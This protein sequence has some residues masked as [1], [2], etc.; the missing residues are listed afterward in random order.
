M[1]SLRDIKKTGVQT[2]KFSALGAVNFIL[3]FALFTV[4]L[5]FFQINY[6]IALFTAWFVGMIFMYVTNF[7][8]VFQSGSPLRF[9]SRFRK[10]MATGIVSITLNMLA[11]HLLVEHAAASPFT[12]Q[13][14]LIP[15]VV[16]FN[17][18]AAKYFSLRRQAA[19]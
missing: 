5:K 9:D 17:F 15:P 10:F 1:A 6:S 19:A 4:L 11:L 7:V 14:L 16:A 12:T 18:L 13:I 8:W 3:T 2:M